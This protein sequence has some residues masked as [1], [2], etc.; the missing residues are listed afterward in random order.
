MVKG[1]E[2]EGRDGE[3]S[4]NWEGVDISRKREVSGDL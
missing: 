1:V 2:I 3:R 4:R